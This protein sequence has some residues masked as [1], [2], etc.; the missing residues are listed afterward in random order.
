VAVYSQALAKIFAA[1]SRIY[2]DVLIVSEFINTYARLKW[3][4]VAPYIN[5]FK[6]FRKSA[7]FKPVAQD[8]AADVKRVLKHCSRIENGFEAL[9]INALIGEYQAGDSDFNDQIIT[10]LCKRKGLT[11]VTDDGYF[12]GQGIPV[13]TANKR[14]L[15][16]GHGP[17]SRLPCYP[18]RPR[19]LEL[20]SV[21]QGCQPGRRK[22]AVKV[23]DI[24]GNGT[25][26]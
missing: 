23:V 16:V 14:L 4:L 20:T 22:I 15:G 10:E 9:D 3:K 13:V 8:V 7:E 24:F 25:I 11:L 26:R 17:A 5:Q 1:Q 19:A 18:K 21:F 12:S 2:I 6:A